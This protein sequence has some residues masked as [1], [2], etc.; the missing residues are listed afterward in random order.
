VA[1]Y[2]AEPR[3]FDVVTARAVASPD[4]LL[5]E[6]LKIVATD[7]LLALFKT[8]APVLSRPET[9]IGDACADPCARAVARSFQGGAARRLKQHIV[10]TWLVL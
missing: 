9:A 5:M 10:V 8:E 4:V 3:S 7:G 2:R 6:L 1:N